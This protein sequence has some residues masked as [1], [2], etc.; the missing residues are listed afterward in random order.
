MTWDS[1]KPDLDPVTGTSFDDADGYFRENFEALELAL[2]E[3]CNF[4]GSI[5]YLEEMGMPLAR[6]Y[7]LAGR[8]GLTPMGN[9][10]ILRSDVRSLDFYYAGIWRNYQMALVGEITMAAFSPA[11]P[12]AGWLACDGAA[13]SQ[14]TYAA[15]YAAIGLT[16]G[17]PGGGDFNLPN[18]EG[19][20][21]IGMDDGDGDYDAIAKSGG[22]SEAT[23]AADE[24]ASHDHRIDAGGVHY[25]LID[26]G[27]NA[28][29]LSTAWLG[30]EV[31]TG[32]VLEVWPH[33]L[34]GDHTHTVDDSG[35]SRDAA[36]AN[37]Q[38][39]LA[40][41]YLIYAGV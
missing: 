34:A 37:K 31:S 17:D 11:S 10:W 23:V 15:L 25:H 22:G 19:R 9:M 5:S 38:P 26:T 27:I 18:T 13:V 16:W 1:S 32:Q 36:H 30:R 24:L 28:G 33:G 4:P 35:E 7:N 29:G 2:S 40:L 6:R 12:P 3:Y 8:G 14:A 39:Y 41:G 21:L 20:V